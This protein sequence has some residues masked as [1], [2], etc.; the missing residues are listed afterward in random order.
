MIDGPTQLSIF[1][2]AVNQPSDDVSLAG[3]A[4]DLLTRINFNL[5]LWNSTVPMY[6]ESDGAD[7]GTVAVVYR[8]VAND[9][10]TENVVLNGTTPVPTA[11]ACKIPLTVKRTATSATRIVTM[12]QGSGGT[13]RGTIPLNEKGFTALFDSAEI[14]TDP[15]YVK[16]FAA[17]GHAVETLINA[18]I[19][20]AA[21]PRQ[22]CRIALE[23]VL[24]GTG[25][26][27]NRK[28][29]P[30]AAIFVDDNI[31]QTVVTGNL[32]ALS[33]Q[34]CYVELTLN[35]ATDLVAFTSS[36]A[37]QLTGTSGG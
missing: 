37:F 34:G 26:L 4:I 29:P 25:T 16:V 35:P 12:K 15:R 19:Y 3:G 9:R 20:I 7:T 28:T 22:K 31:I 32:P 17:N 6:F 1:Y 13:I 21:D 33:R 24:N 11:Q 2:A 8:N 14:D 36:V 27:P 10:V 5:T 18:T 23:E 30:A